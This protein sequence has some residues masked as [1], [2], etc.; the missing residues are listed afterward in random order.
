M[1]DIVK[2]HFHGDTIE[3][4]PGDG[5]AWVVVRRVCEALGI[6]TDSQR[7]KLRTMPWAV[8]VMNT[9][10]GP[11]GKNY[12]SFCIDLDSLPMWLA[13]I[14]PSR[15]R[16]EI[17][18]KLERYQK[19]CARVLRDHFFGPRTVAQ[20][21]SISPEALT[22]AITEG[23]K[24]AMASVMP[25]VMARIDDLLSEFD[26]RLQR[27]EQGVPQLS[28]DGSIG[29]RTARAIVLHKLTA[30]AEMRTGDMEHGRPYMSARAKAD[31]ELRSHLGWSGLGRT[32]AAFPASRL[33]EAAVKLREME[34]RAKEEE[35]ALAKR[36]Q[37]KLFGVN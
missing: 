15:V 35:K 3:A 7:K 37:A 25:I 16:P 2:V 30:I 33:G 6:D 11:D 29:Q 19:E 24:A 8:T 13:T 27:V 18:P 12:Q 14:Q 31:G 36:A 22:A 26:A 28:T 9:A 1:S 34:R 32:W 5:T 20:S 4:I 21:I 17:R 23:V 10:T